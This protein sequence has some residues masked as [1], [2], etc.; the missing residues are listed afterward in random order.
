MGASVVV[1]GLGPAGPDLVTAATQA[2]L[3]RVPRRFL[4]TARHPSAHV[5][6]DA[7]TF[8]HIYEEAG[9]LDGVYATIVDRLVKAAQAEGEVLYAVPGSPVVAERTVELLRA[10]GRVHVTV[11]PALSFLDLVWTSLGVDPMTAGMRLVDGHRFATEAAGAAGPLLVAQCDH[12]SVLSQ[13]KLALEDDGPAVTVLQRLGLPDAARFEVA[14]ADLDRAFTPDH[15]TTLWVPPLTAPVAAELVRFHELVHT[16]RSQCPWDRRQTHASL[17]RHL[18][19]ESYEVLD[20]IDAL[21]ANDPA[22]ADHLQEE[23]GDLLFQVEFHAVI[24]EQDGRFTM[25]DVARGIHDKLV[26]RHPHVFAT[27][28]ADSAEAVLANWEELKRAEKGRASVLDGIPR[29]LPALARANE[30]QRKAATVG[31]DWDDVGGALPKIAEEAAELAAVT[32]QPERAADELGDLLFAVVNV[33]RHLGVDPEA[34]L[35]HAT[36]KFQGRFEIM[37]RLATASGVDLRRLDL[38]ALD[39]LWAKAKSM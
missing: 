23:L 12:R 3:D 15:L 20:A 10:D 26:R 27:A 16:L 30:T 7:T 35:R 17:T 14:W 22:T 31:F 6:A 34:A 1:V 19:E 21:D 39:A 11:V 33:A 38:D 24:A 8:D 37:E 13:I 4:R 9:T 25:A 5:V 28:T 32:E 18:L 29:S 2:A 36:D